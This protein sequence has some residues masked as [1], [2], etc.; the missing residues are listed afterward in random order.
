MWKDE[1]V[2]SW[3]EVIREA[4]QEGRE[5]HV[6]SLHELVVEKGSELQLGDKN[7]KL[8]GRV[9]F[10]GDRVRDAEGKHAVFEELSSS[11]AAMSAGKFADAY[12]CMPGNTIQTADGIQAYPQAKMSSNTKT[13][14]RLPPHRRP[15]AFDN[16]QDP[17]VE[18]THA[19]YG[20]PDAA[21]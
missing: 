10:L 13:W 20:H 7:R 11:P 18:M 2:R 1:D 6:G 17:V 14:I 4:R 3:S 21:A 8:K 12:G 9:V 5:V 15:K 19:L 16:V